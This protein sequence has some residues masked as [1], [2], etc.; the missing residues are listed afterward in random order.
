M[1]IPTT[2]GRLVKSIYC[3]QGDSL[4]RA[5]GDVGHGR[6]TALA[7]VGRAERVARSLRFRT[8]DKERVSTARG[9]GGVIGGDPQIRSW[10]RRA[11][12]AAFGRAPRI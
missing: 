5:C 4:E 1:L 12:I 9:G 2:K 3:V 7:A 11:S 8:R 6:G 10:S